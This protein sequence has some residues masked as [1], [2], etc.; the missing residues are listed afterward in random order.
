MDDTG[1]WIW[2]F[3]IVGGVAIMGIIMAVVTARYS[4]TH[5]RRSQAEKRASKAV[6]EE[7][8]RHPVKQD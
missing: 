7:N 1:Y 5:A 4:R 3:A 8:Y 2:G 6:T